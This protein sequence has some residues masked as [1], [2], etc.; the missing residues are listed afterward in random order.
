MQERILTHDTEKDKY[1]EEFQ[2][3]KKEYE[4]VIKN[5]EDAIPKYQKKNW[6]L[7]QENRDLNLQLDGLRDL[8]NEVKAMNSLQPLKQEY[9]HIAE[10][11]LLAQKDYQFYKAE[12]K[13]K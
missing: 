6:D 2:K 7:E 10:L 12:E 13:L 8:L 1:I 11:K 4:E 9:R 5:L 3:L